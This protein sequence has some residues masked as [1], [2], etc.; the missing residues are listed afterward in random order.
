MGYQ[1]SV[2]VTSCSS[3]AGTA[4]VKNLSTGRTVTKAFTGTAPLGGQNTEWIVE[5]FSS[6][7]S[8]LPFAKFGT[9]MFSNAVARYGGWEM[10]RMSGASV[11]EIESSGGTVPTEVTV[12]SGSSVST[13][14]D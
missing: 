10:E 13:T 12:F 1:I 4:L 8:L 11:V 5:N 6:G 9:V 7:D 2:F 3:K 14:C